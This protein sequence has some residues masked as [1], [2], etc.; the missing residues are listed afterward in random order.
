MVVMAQPDQTGQR[1]PGRIPKSASPAARQ[2]VMGIDTRFAAE[3]EASVAVP[4]EPTG[5]V[6]C[7]T[8]F[9]SPLKQDGSVHAGEASRSGEPVVS[10]E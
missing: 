3:D 7:V 6:C 5:D 10:A 1:K 2:P 8:Q 9:S 4:D